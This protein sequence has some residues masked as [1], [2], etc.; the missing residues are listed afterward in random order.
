MK[1]KVK[2]SLRP[3]FKPTLLAAAIASSLVPGL[4]NG[5]TVVVTHFDDDSGEE[6]INGVTVDLVCSLR[7]AINSFNNEDEEQGCFFDGVLGI[8]DAVLSYGTAF[9]TTAQLTVSPP[10][11]LTISLGGATISG[12]GTHRIMD[13]TGATVTLEDMTLRYGLDTS[14]GGGGLRIQTGSTVTI[15]NS[16]ISSNN[17][18]GDGGGILING[19]SLSITNGSLITNNNVGAGYGGGI[20]A[21]NATISIND[22]TV[23]SN[24]A[25]QGGGLN[26]TAGTPLSLSLVNS[27]ISYNYAYTGAGILLSTGMLTANNTTFSGN[28]ATN[29]GALNII[30]GGSA[31]LD[32]TTFFGNEAPGSGGASFYIFGEEYSEVTV[33][34]TNSVLSNG[35][36]GSECGRNNQDLTGAFNT[37]IDNGGNWFEDDSCNG[38]AQGDPKLQPLAANGGPTMTHLPTIASPLRNLADSNCTV[39]DQR[40]RSRGPR[41]DTGAVEFVSAEIY[42]DSLLDDG[43]GCTLREAIMSKSS[44]TL[45]PGCTAGEPLDTAD[46]RSIYFDESIAGQTITLGGPQLTVSGGDRVEINPDRRDGISL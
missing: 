22:S 6:E 3:V 30:D 11:P 41:C 26:F 23:S 40:G 2:C 5:A 4:G 37:I 25:S 36:G 15:S 39:N 9:S 10:N 32:H 17:A 42:V 8:D 38:V 7:E 16:T 31:V 20:Q 34:L 21:N 12:Q 1:Y 28:T 35:L 19:A 44:A 45:Q 33:T 24:T 13:V 14:V 46:G 27:T 18:L 29:Y 43:T